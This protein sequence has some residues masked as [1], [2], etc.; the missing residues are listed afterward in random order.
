MEIFSV[1]NCVCVS[2]GVDKWPGISS[3]QRLGRGKGLR[4]ALDCLERLLGENGWILSQ[5]SVGYG[6]R[7]FIL[8]VGA[9]RLL[10]RG[11]CSG[12]KKRV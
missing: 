9:L 2:L 1:Q 7:E 10:F 12:L 5:E 3:R 11:H 8:T 4:T 6:K